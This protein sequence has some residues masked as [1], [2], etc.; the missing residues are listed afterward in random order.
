MGQSEKILPA[1]AL[2]ERILRYNMS[3]NCFKHFFGEWSWW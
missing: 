1:D 3:A 2:G